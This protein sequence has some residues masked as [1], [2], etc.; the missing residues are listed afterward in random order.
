MKIDNLK[1]MTPP[2]SPA[3]ETQKKDPRLMEAAKMYEKQFLR[4][5]VK[6]MRSTVPEAG[7]IEVSQ[8]EKIFREQL[9]D[10]YVDNW[11]DQG[12]IGLA[13]LIYKQIEERFGSSV[14]GVA[15]KNFHSHFMP[16]PKDAIKSVQPKEVGSGLQ[17]DFKSGANE[18]SAVSLPYS[19]KL[20]AQGPRD[21]LT[22]WAKVSHDGGLVSD[23]LFQGEHNPDLQVGAELPAGATMGWLRPN[24][25]LLWNL[26]QGSSGSSTNL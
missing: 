6:Q 22:R 14:K 23:I 21:E 4:E 13:N 24:A 15:R 5:M 16:L 7:L 25:S 1:M 8:G 26:S 9:D 11:G 12:G 20:L 3:E 2:A 18:K 10:Q 17:F 19:G